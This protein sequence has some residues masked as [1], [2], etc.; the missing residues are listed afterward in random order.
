MGRGD[1][2]PQAFL[3]LTPHF[4]PVFVMPSRAASCLSPSWDE[5]QGKN[6][7]IIKQLFMSMFRNNC[8]LYRSS[9]CVFYVFGSELAKT[10]RERV[11]IDAAAFH[12]G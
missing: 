8:E 9:V 1:L 10:G 12:K 3:S 6:L 7:S 5:T 11:S 4:L 2:L